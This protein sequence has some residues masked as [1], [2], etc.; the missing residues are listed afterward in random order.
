MVELIDRVEFT[1]DQFDRFSLPK[2]LQEKLEPGM[3]HV[4]ETRYND[5]IGLRI[6]RLSATQDIN[7][8]TSSTPQ[9]STKMVSLWSEVKLPRV[10]RG[11]SFFRVA[12][13][14]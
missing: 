8:E 3:V 11:M 14:P 7:E 9:L 5:A 4:V 10:L 6:Q 1:V 13:N 12:K 2:E